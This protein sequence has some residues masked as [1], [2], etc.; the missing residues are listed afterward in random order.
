M[1]SPQPLRTQSKYN[2][3]NFMLLGLVWAQHTNGCTAWDKLNQSS[4]VPAALQDDIVFFEHGRCTKYPNVAHF[5]E[6][7]GTDPASG[8]PTFTD[9]IGTRYHLSRHL[10]AIPTSLPP[11]PTSHPPHTA[12]SVGGHSEILAPL[13]S[14]LPLSFTIF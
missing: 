6:H 10:P 3:I 5:Y 4:V 9:M 7:T 14:V 12:V 11:Y 13:Q 1:P 8:L 2:S